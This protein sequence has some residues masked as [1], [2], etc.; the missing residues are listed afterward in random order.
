MRYKPSFNSSYNQN[1]KK[2]KQTRQ[3]TQGV[4]RHTFFRSCPSSFDSW[5]RNE[6]YFKRSSSTSLSFANS[7]RSKSSIIY[8]R[9]KMRTQQTSSHAGAC[10][11][12]KPSRESACLFDYSPRS[13]RPN[14]AWTAWSCPAPQQ[15][16]SRAHA[17]A[18]AS[19]SPPDRISLAPARQ[20]QSYTALLKRRA[21]GLYLFQ[22]LM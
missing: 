18:P 21:F 9:N 6:M 2:C 7:C 20:Q 4:G 1:N 14:R 15:P 16:S 13:W 5:L 10:Y 19:P 17:D 22:V 3:N 12:Y 8:N 11:P